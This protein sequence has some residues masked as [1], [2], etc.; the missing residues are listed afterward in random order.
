MS[1]WRRQIVSGDINTR[2]IAP[3]P[4]HVQGANHVH[5]GYGVSGAKREWLSASCEAVS[6]VTI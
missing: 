3:I 6:I 4:P 2:A 5:S 1:P